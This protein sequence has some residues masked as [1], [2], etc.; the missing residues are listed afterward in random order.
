MHV[1]VV[2]LGGIGQNLVHLLIGHKDDVAVIDKNEVR[3]KDIASKHD[4]LAIVG[5]A[6]D[7]SV[8]ED[9]GG[10]DANAL[11]IT[12]ADDATNL[13]TALVGKE[14]DIKNIIS[15]VN[16]QDHVGMFRRIGVNVEENPDMAVA[17]SLRRSIIR[18]S[19]KE[20]LSVAGG[21][22][23]IFEITVAES[24]KAANK[25]ISSLPLSKDA[26]IIAIER[27]KGVIIPKGDTVLMPGDLVTIFAMSRLVDKTAK[28]FYPREK[29]ENK[30]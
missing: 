4:L 29:D 11:I 20:H 10:A 9:A 28:L 12:T 30:E 17:Q 26:L 13:M 1:I 25:A 5:D 24:S 14:L 19:V 16:Q 7:Q 23:E 18:P 6:T 21:K 8:L 15:V 2:G 3:C 27:D 22:A